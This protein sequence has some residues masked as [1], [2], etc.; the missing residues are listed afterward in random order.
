MKLQKRDCTLALARSR[1][2]TTSTSM[3]DAARIFHTSGCTLAS[4]DPSAHRTP[5]RPIAQRYTRAMHSKHALKSIAI[6]AVATLLALPALAQWQWIDKEGRKV[7][8]DQPPPAEIR[9]KDILKRPGGRI[10]PAAATPANNDMTPSISAPALRASASIA[11]KLSSMDK[12]LEARKQQADAAEVLKKK[13]EEDKQ[14]KARAEN[15]DRAKNALASLQSGM[16]I[17]VTNAAGER[18]IMDDS[19]RATEIQRTKDIADGSCK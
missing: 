19:K 11:P 12:E 1:T 17:G 9:D 14:V 13:T 4:P 18:E 15:C 6:A 7:Y 10:T 8:S 3:V 2:G 16:R 5:Y